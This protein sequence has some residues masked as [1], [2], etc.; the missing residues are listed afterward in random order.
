MENNFNP[1]QQAPHFFT[2]IAFNILP[3][4][5]YEKILIFSQIVKIKKSQNEY[6]TLVDS[7][8]KIQWSKISGME[9]MEIEKTLS[10]QYNGDKFVV[11]LIGQAQHSKS[12]FEFVTHLKAALDSMAV[13]LNSYLQIGL[14]GGERDFNKTK[15]TSKLYEKDSK[16]GDIIKELTKINWFLKNHPNIDSI[17][18]TRDEWIHKGSPL[19]YALAPPSEEIGHLPI[20][21]DL[22]DNSNN[23]P[24]NSRSY[25]ST[26][27]FYNFHFEKVSWLFN[28]VL[29][30]LIEVEKGNID[31]KYPNEDEI[32]MKMS[33][34][35]L[36][37]TK[38]VPNAQIY[39][40]FENPG[41]VFNVNEMLEDLSQKVIRK[42][43]EKDRETFEKLC[44]VRT[45][46]YKYDKRF[47]FILNEEITTKF[48]KLTQND[49]LSLMSIGLLYLVDLVPKDG[50]TII[51]GTNGLILSRDENIGGTLKLISLTH[52]GM[53]V[54][55]R[56]KNPELNVVYLEK[57]IRVINELKF[58][59]DLVA[60]SNFSEE[61]FAF[62]SIRQYKYSD[63]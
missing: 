51:Y 2:R 42:L 63:I 37:G 38:D 13:F 55:L 29:D 32:K 20:P 4:I 27:D 30:R 11:D 10:S 15:F 24:L 23:K 5:E 16:I 39:F 34:F 8:M 33:F 19:I 45:Q 26:T 58:N 57:L 43:T 1:P 31:I 17:V 49:I 44:S 25:S 53:E 54:F 22:K 18:S 12:I 28:S 14:N 21:R 9:A 46:V 47:I 48:L 52:I 61:S 59:V 3:E 35:P 56:M 60:I 41:R 40:K 6:V 7:L 50:F 62:D 36:K